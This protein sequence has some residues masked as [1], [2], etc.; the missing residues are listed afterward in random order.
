MKTTTLAIASLALSATGA[1]AARFS[2]AKITRAINDVRVFLSSG[3]SRPANIGY[4]VDRDNSVLTG[5]KSRA[6]LTFPDDS[7]IRLGQNTSF[8]FLG[9][10]REINVGEGTVLLQQPKWR[11]RTKIRTAAVS[12]A[13]TGTTVIVESSP[14]PDKKG[15]GK[16]RGEVVAAAEPHRGGGRRLFGA[17]AP[18]AG[19]GNG[20][21]KLL[22]LEGSMRFN[23]VAAPNKSMTLKPGE[24]VS[25]PFGAVELPRKFIFD[26]NQLKKTSGLLGPVQIMAEE[27]QEPR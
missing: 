18:P 2:A 21:V 7:I 13:I 27:E 23:L 26:I 8:S 22:V 15:F 5:K 10:R 14:L 20:I 17:P 4:T 25:M 1:H 9:G 16:K 12:A 6:E 24:M 11:G 19:L 3:G